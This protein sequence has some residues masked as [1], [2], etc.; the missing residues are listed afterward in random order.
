MAVMN[1]QRNQQRLVYSHWLTF[2]TLNSS[3]SRMEDGERLTSTLPLD[4]L[5]FQE[6][7]WP[8]ELACGG[9]QKSQPAVEWI[10]FK[11]RHNPDPHG[12]RGEVAE[13]LTHGA[14]YGWAN[15][16]KQ[17]SMKVKHHF[18]LLKAPDNLNV[19]LVDIH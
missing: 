16:W 18:I 14:Y 3:D 10:S 11:Q 15:S 8:R 2:L 5:Q 13:P 19:C 17:N 4:C 1:S 7:G 12:P 9:K 6:L